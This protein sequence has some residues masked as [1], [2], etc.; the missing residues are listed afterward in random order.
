MNGLFYYSETQGQLSLP[1]VKVNVQASIK[2][3]SASIQLEQHFH[4][5]TRQ[6]LE[7]AYTFPVP[8]RAVVHSFTLVK[9]DGSRVVGIVQEKAQARETYETA[10]SEGKVASLLEQDTPDGEYV[11][12]ALHSLSLTQIF[13]LQSSASW[14]AMSCPTRRCRCI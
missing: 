4:N 5:E 3:L 10:V 9:Q 12:S 7:C 6:S 8:A 2:D 1:L 14:L 11:S 13:H